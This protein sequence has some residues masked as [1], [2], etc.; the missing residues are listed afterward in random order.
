MPRALNFTDLQPGLEIDLGPDDNV[1]LREDNVAVL[2]DTTATALVPIGSNLV[3][4]ERFA[5]EIDNPFSDFIVTLTIEVPMSGN[6]R[7]VSLNVLGRRGE[8]VDGAALRSLRISFLLKVAC[9]VATI[10]L[11]RLPDSTMFG[12]RSLDG[13]GNPE[14]VEAWAASVGREK[15]KRVT[16]DDLREIAEHYREA[17]EDGD[18][19]PTVYAARKMFLTRSTAGRWIQRARAAGFLGAAIDRRPGEQT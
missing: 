15:K 3:L 4:P 8:T 19:A 10:K 12:G 13:A 11:E 2:Y 17:L 1:E 18:P 16:D 6:P 7:C 14:F 9:R 5:A